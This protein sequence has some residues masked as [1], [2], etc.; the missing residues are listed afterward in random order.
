MSGKNTDDMDRADDMDKDK[1]HMCV[2]FRGQLSK[3]PWQYFA[4]K[5]IWLEVGNNDYSAETI[6]TLIF[7]K[8]EEDFNVCDASKHGY[9]IV[10]ALQG[11]QEHQ[12]KV[13]SDIFLTNENVVF[14]KTEFVYR[15]YRSKDSCYCTPGCIL[16][17]KKRKGTKN[18]C[19]YQ[20]YSQ[21]M[22]RND[23]CGSLH[24]Q[25]KKRVSFEEFDEDEHKGFDSHVTGSNN[26]TSD[27]ATETSLTPIL[28]SGNR[29]KKD[30]NGEA[31][32][33]NTSTTLTI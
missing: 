19:T 26:S 30:K 2:S 23:D 10:K 15:L 8:I 13:L 16:Y 3:L 4:G 21:D 33:G 12:Y 28:Q 29:G 5:G 14:G 6:R 22:K 27:I 31:P 9:I 17:C 7:S 25:D 24:Y 20:N 18:E 1:C 11:I 32:R